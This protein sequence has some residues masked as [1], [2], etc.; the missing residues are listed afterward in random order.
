MALRGIV[1]DAYGTLLD[2]HSVVPDKTLSALWRQKQL[3]Y[4][5]LRALM[6]RYEDFAKVTEDALRAAGA[7]L[8]INLTEQRIA[9]I[10]EAYRR[11]AAF[12]DARLALERLKGRQLAILSNGT[13][14]MLEAALRHNR[15]EAYFE[16]IISVDRVKSYKPAPKVYALGPEALK[17]PVSEILFVSSNAWDA[18]GAKAFGYPVCWVNRSRVEM[19]RLGS[20]PDVIVNSLAEL[21]GAIEI[22]G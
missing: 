6:E 18:A 19:E 1:F 16:A 2:V 10:L 17:L 8:R 15:L 7:Q 4:T 3:E 20:D 9:D 12:D 11:P 13:V 22:A 14:P 21:A 5:W